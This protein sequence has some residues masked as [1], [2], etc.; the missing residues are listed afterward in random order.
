MEMALIYSS[1]STVTNR[2]VQQM[3]AEFFM[4]RLQEENEYGGGGKVALFSLYLAGCKWWLLKK[5]VRCVAS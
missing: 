2:A 5:L 4:R 1:G 3:L